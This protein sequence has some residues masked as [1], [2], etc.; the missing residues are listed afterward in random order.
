[1][2]QNTCN[3][4]SD[5]IHDHLIPRIYSYEVRYAFT[6]EW[7]SALDCNHVQPEP[8]IHVLRYVHYS[9]MLEIVASEPSL[10]T[11]C[12]IV[13]PQI[14]FFSSFNDLNHL[15]VHP[16]TYLIHQTPLWLITSIVWLC[17]T[18]TI[19]Y[20]YSRSAWPFP[21]TVPIFVYTSIRR[22]GYYC[23]IAYYFRTQFANYWLNF[24][25]LSTL[26]LSPLHF[27]PVASAKQTVNWGPSTKLSCAVYTRVHSSAQWWLLRH[28]RQTSNLTPAKL[29]LKLKLKSVAWVR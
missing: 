17:R 20:I 22:F 12:R 6:W 1:M 2:N 26:S 18:Y 8:D 21:A 27:G 24:C 14:L 7:W 10:S 25:L 9:V 16:F 5:N 4:F 19:T 23:W 3:C 29:K 28:A 15:H 11:Y 13:D